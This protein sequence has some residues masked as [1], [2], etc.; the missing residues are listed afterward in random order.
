MP[1]FVFIRF[2]GINR[3]VRDCVVR[4]CLRTILF[5]LVDP[6]RRLFNQSLPCKL[7]MLPQVLKRPFSCKVTS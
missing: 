4:R 5:R 2:N 1:I 3:N 7:T 6:T